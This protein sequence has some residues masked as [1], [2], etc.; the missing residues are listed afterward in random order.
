MDITSLGYSS[1]LLQHGGFILVNCDVK[2]TISV[3]LRIPKAGCSFA[4]EYA[5]Q[6]VPIIFV[7]LHVC[8]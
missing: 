6:P 1:D 2:A 5:C 4:F 3:L 7:L 8:L